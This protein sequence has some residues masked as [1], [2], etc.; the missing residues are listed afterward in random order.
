MKTDK[1]ARKKAL[2]H[3]LQDTENAKH[4][5]RIEP[6]QQTKTCTEK[7]QPDIVTEQ[8]LISQCQSR[9]KQTAE[10][11]FG[12]FIQRY[13]GNVYTYLSY[14]VEN[15]KS[16]FEMMQAVF[17][18]A[19]ENIPQFHGE[20]SVNT[21]LLKITEEHLRA[22]SQK[23]DTGPQQ[24][25]DTDHHFQ[26]DSPTGGSECQDIHSLLSAYAGD[27][28]DESDIPRVETHLD[29][30]TQCWLEYEE[31]KDALDAPAPAFA[32]VPAP[33]DA[34]R[35]ILHTLFPKPSLWKQ[36]HALLTQF[37]LGFPAAWPQIV[38]VAAAA[39]LVVKL[40]GM[41]GD[42]AQR[43]QIDQL[44]HDLLT[45]SENRDIDDL[46]QE[47]QIN[48]VVIFT[49]E[50]ASEE[51]S[52]EAL[53]YA[54]EILPERKRLD[55]TK[56]EIPNGNVT[57]IGDTLVEDI[58]AAHGT[59]THDD[60]EPTQNTLV[61]RKIAARIPK[62]SNVF[63]A[64]VLRQLPPQPSETHDSSDIRMTPVTFYLIDKER[65]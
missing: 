58:R 39:S 8:D 14:N 10:A 26:D 11:A 6:D 42:Y 36:C 5:D 61:V 34:A 54:A 24:P 49:G 33:E 25:A 40:I 51:L 20:F 62:N 27:E 44:G 15:D 47:L 57:D 7:V 21:W 55:E 53:S 9:N 50:L 43:E 3:I 16:A 23:C 18:R 1:K 48:T 64:L 29:V 41:P 45:V 13:Q 2:F 22:V 60:L 12:Q 46:S 59:I 28:L 52:E 65:E 19:Y 30:C 31:L 56:T 32:P 37:V 35:Q 38:T 63:I 4:V 17:L